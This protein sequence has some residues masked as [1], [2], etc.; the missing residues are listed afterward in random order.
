MP[1]RWALLE[2]TISIRRTRQEDLGDCWRSPVAS[3]QNASCVSA[4]RCDLDRRGVAIRDVDIAGD[5]VPGEYTVEVTVR[6]A[7]TQR[8]G[9]AALRIREP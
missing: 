3:G 7:S 8:S 6:T 2:T 4:S 1:R 9:R 5:L